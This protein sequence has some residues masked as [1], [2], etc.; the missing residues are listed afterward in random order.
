MTIPNAVSNQTVHQTT[1]A[2]GA[3]SPLCVEA[4]EK[5]KSQIQVSLKE[6]EGESCAFRLQS[7]QSGGSTTCPPNWI[8]QVGTSEGQQLLVGGDQESH[9]IKVV[10][11][12]TWRYTP[13]YPKDD[14][15]RDRCAFFKKIKAT[16]PDVKPQG[17]TCEK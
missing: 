12:G 14:S 6:V 11:S 17:F 3:Q 2:S 15:V 13:A 4:F 7:N 1:A 8:C 10:G 9:P 16:T 5:A